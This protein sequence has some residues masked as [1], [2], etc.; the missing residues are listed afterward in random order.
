MRRLVPWALL[1]L[2]GVGAGV[3]AALGQVNAPETMDVSIS[4]APWVAG[5][6]AATK[7]AGTAHLHFTGAAA[8]PNPDLRG[9][10]SGSGVVDFA[11]GSFRVSEEDHGIQWSSEDGGPLHRS[12]VIDREEQIAVGRTLYFADLAVPDSWVSLTGGTRPGLL[13]LASVGGFGAA[14]APLTGAVKAIGVRD[15]G[16]TTVDGKPAT[17]YLVQSEP[18]AICPKS[19]PPKATTVVWVDD[20]GRMVQARFWFYFG[21]KFP[22]SPPRAAAGLHAPP[23]GPRTFTETIQ[24]TAFGAPVRITA[25]TLAAG[26]PELNLSTQSVS[27]SGSSVARCP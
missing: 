15:L 9:S 4:P 23:E 20:G 24:L 14:L 13:G 22:K 7:A 1:L 12:P 3:G 17:R 21:G 25:P 27:I 10:A 16:P 26:S 6:L 2:I 5:V 19:R 11:T 8:S 18:T